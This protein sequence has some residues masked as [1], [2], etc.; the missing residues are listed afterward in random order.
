[1]SDHIKIQHKRGIHLYSTCTFS[2]PKELQIHKILHKF[3]QKK[4]SYIFPLK[5]SEHNFHKERKKISLSQTRTHTCTKVHIEIINK[6]RSNKKKKRS[7]RWRERERE[8][9]AKEKKRKFLKMWI[10]IYTYLIY[11]GSTLTVNKIG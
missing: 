11:N 1:M 9:R 2:L 4:L 3:N 8:R 7:K 10:D 6:L 5:D